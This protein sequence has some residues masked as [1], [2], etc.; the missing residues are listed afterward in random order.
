MY[1]LCSQGFDCW[2]I[3]VRGAGLSEKSTWQKRG[4]GWDLQTYTEDI[5]LAIDTCLAHF[6]VSKLHYLGRSRTTAGYGSSALTVASTGRCCRTLAGRHAGSRPARP[7]PGV[8][9]QGHLAHHAGVRT[10]PRG[11]VSGQWRAVAD[12]TEQSR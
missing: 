12:S 4:R 10:L 3:D 6:G 5:K 7:L 11:L 8:R 1:V 2:V 9:G